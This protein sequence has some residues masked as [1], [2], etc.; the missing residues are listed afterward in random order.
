MRK[1]LFLCAMVCLAM[2][3]LASAG[4][5]DVFGY[6][7]ETTE[8]TYAAGANP[9][10]LYTVN[11]PDSIT[12]TD[13][14]AGWASI[15]MPLSI[16]PGDVLSYDRYLSN[17]MRDRVGGWALSSWL[18]DYQSMPLDTTGAT[19]DAYFEYADNNRETWAHTTAT[20]WFEIAASGSPTA[21]ASTGIHY[22]FAFGAASYTATM[23]D[24][25]T[26]AQIATGTSALDPA[27]IGY[28]L[29]GLWDT[30]QDMTI[31]N[32]VVTPEPATLLLLGLGGVLLRRKRV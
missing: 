10:I 21:L 17:D 15:S 2:S 31:E 5:V 26:G 1:L 8:G 29:F 9:E 23:T 30:E 18:A 22:D 19:L 13:I 27:L 24:I 14:W 3:H 4:T 16:S 7:W 11:N 32:F 12:V 25:V 28:W 20:D 6:T